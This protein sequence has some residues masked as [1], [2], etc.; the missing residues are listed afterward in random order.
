MIELEEITSRTVA[1]TSGI[2]RSANFGGI[3]LNNFTIAIDATSSFELGKEFRKKLENKFNLPIKYLFLTHT[4]TDHRNGL[5][6]FQDIPLI[7]S[8]FCIRNMPK[9]QKLNDITIRS[10]SDYY[11]IQDGTD[12]VEFHYTG[13]HTIGS[14][15]AY[16]PTEKVLFS[17]D[18][19]FHIRFNFGIP[20][21][22]FYQNKVFDNKSKKTGNPEE[23]IR[24]FEKLKTMDIEVIVGGH[25][26][27]IFNPVDVIKEQLNLFRKVKSSTLEVI[28]NNERMDKISLQ[29]I[30]LVQQAFEN[31]KE[32]KQNA[33]RCR[34]WLVNYLK[35]LKKTFY[36]YYSEHQDS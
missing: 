16:F 25:G 3:A 2:K 36:T 22:V 35:M 11:S 30:N 32:R 6:A 14:S 26:P 12:K 4:H 17:G 34:N 27:V 5:K 21:L 19:I 31:C 28:A 23:Y 24:A 15:I 8:E 20:V 9:S 1:H 7:A 18:L 10:F 29:N 13:G 33:S